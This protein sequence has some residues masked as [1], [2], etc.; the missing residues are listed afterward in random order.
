MYVNVLMFH[1]ECLP[2]TV[3]CYVYFEAFL[4][5]N[6]EIGME[7]DCHVLSL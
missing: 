5:Q 6:R 7:K 2:V 3:L 4:R 1:I